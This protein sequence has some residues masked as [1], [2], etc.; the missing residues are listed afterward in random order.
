MVGRPC[1]AALGVEEGITP[2][3]TPTRSSEGGLTVTSLVVSW[4]TSL[5]LMGV[6]MNTGYFNFVDF[7]KAFA[8][9]QV[10]LT[11]LLKECI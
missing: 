3:P 6:R 2:I 11:Y 4:S 9:S 10:E 5:F 1:C 8:S 7:N